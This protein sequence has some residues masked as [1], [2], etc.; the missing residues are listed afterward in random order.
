MIDKEIIDKNWNEIVYDPDCD[1]HWNNG[2]EWGF[3]Q[4]IEFVF[5]FI[6]HNSNEIPDRNI[7]RDNRGELCLVILKSG[8]P[9][10]ARAY[11]IPSKD[12]Y[13]FET[14]DANGDDINIDYIEKWAYIND[15]NR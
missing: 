12:M 6:W 13:M 15:L 7:G 9:I 5:K 2:S 10:V 14:Y 3:K 11:Y 8:D 4:G 1:D